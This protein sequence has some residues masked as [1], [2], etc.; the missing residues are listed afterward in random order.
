MDYP[1]EL[2]KF[3]LPQTHMVSVIPAGDVKSEFKQPCWS[4]YMDALNNLR[5]LRRH[6]DINPVMQSLD[7]GSAILGSEFSEADRKAYRAASDDLK[8]LA[9]WHDRDAVVEALR[10]DLGMQ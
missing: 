5:Y 4:R 6:H 10:E 2:T 7:M 3:S 1:Y 8:F 9:Q